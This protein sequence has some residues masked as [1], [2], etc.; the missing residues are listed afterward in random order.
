MPHVDV[1]VVSYNSSKTLRRCLEPLVDADNVRLIVV[2]NN[3]ADSSLATIADLEP[4]IILLKENRGFA[5]GCN[6]GAEAGSAPFV[7]F[8]NPDASI[9]PKALEL[10]V[11][12]IEQASMIGAV[13]PLIRE[14]SGVA[15]FSLRRFPRLRSSFARALFLHRILP[16][17]QWADELVRDPTAYE[18]R[19]TI[20]WASGACMLVRRT[21]FNKIGG[22][23]ERF[24]M[25]CEDTDLCLRLQQAGYSIVFEPSSVVIHTGAVSAPR[26]SMIPTLAHSRI[27]FARKHHSA[28]WTLLERLG[29]L[30]EAITRAFGG[31]RGLRLGHLRSIR[32]I[33]SMRATSN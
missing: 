28:L 7:L 13:T 11:E 6:R 24:F 26:A 20:E 10:L 17:L 31:R 30:L 15:E 8:L 5:F 14:E 22:F 2:D 1:V 19:G 18:S 9:Q 12:S 21:A 27:R 3:S 33:L 32:T 29:L 4:S 16:R 25:Y 23:D